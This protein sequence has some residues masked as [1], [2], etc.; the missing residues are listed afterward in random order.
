ML[1]PAAVLGRP[2]KTADEVEP[3]EEL[4]ASTELP[5]APPLPVA[6]DDKLV[7]VTLLPIIDV[8]LTASMLVFDPVV[9]DA[10]ELVFPP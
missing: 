1:D 2:P 9:D 6:A 5:P 10:L 4:A 7:V 8:P 3:E